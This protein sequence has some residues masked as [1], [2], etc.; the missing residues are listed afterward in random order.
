[1]RSPVLEPADSIDAVPWWH[2]ALG[3]GG[4]AVL[5]IWL[6]AVNPWML[7]FV[8]GIIASVVLHE[9]GHFVTAR[10]SGMKVTQFFIGFGPRLWSTRRGEVE[11]GVRLLPLGAFVRIIGM[12]NLDETDDGDE[13]RTYRQQG[14]GRRLLVVSAG[15]L[16]HAILAI[17]LLVGVYATFGPLGETG[18]V[19]VTGV[20]MGSP[21]EVA[22][23]RVDDRIVS[24]DG[25]PMSS[26][27][28]FV[29]T[30]QRG[31]PGD[32]IDLVIERDQQPLVL[33]AGLG[34]NP[35]PG[36]EGVAYLGVGSDSMGRVRA[37][38][39]SAVVDGVKDLGLGVWDSIRGVVI[40]LNPVN[41]VQHVMGTAD[42]V[43]TRPTTLVGATQVSGAVGE[44]D[45]VAGVLTVLA[46][47]NIFVGVI[48]MAPL[49]PL[50]G[51]HASIVVYERLRSRRGR[52]YQADV[53]KMMPVATAVITVL[54]LLLLA[55]LYLDI[56]Q[57]LG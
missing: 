44:R 35:N 5:L 39:P 49:L 31:R 20:A 47:V 29:D 22:G 26:R 8:V 27:R 51:G 7:M 55:G 46:A 42:D 54:G 6:G 21:A 9:V 17:A 15:S 50:D 16:M 25:Q 33:E 37:P 1:M 53:S 48:N 40:V 11:Y 24:F 23:L 43:T 3:F 52:R 13:P 57:P 30:I 38:L 19:R 41:V 56:T 14:F 4:L 28:E 10:R 2:S 34:S 32:R 45:G 18:E 36:F 12:N